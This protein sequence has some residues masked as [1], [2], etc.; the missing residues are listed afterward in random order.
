MPSVISNRF[1]Y[2]LLS[3]VAMMPAVMPVAVQASGAPAVVPTPAPPS[4]ADSDR[5]KLQAMDAYLQAQVRNDMFSGTALVTRDGEPVFVKSYGMANYELGAANTSDTTYPLGSV[6]K[7]FTAVAILQLQEQGKLKVG[8]PICRYLE[9][10][11]QSWQ[12]ITLHHLLTHTSGIPNF[13]GLPGW[14]EKLAMLS[15]TR[16]ELVALFRDLPLDF[17]PG[18]K[19][20][21]SNSGY[22]LLGVIIERVSGQRYDDYLEEKIFKPVGMTRT[23][24]GETRALVP[25]RATGYYSVGTDFISAR[26]VSPTSHLGTSGV[27]STV[28]DL[29]LWDK[30]LTA[31]RLISR[32]SRDAMFTPE[33][34]SYG[35]GWFVGER[36]GRPTQFHSGSDNGF[37]TNITRFPADGL[38]VIVLSNSDRTNA[39]GVSNDLAAIAFGA[40]YKL[41]KERL[42]DVLWNVMRDRG[43]TAALARHAELKRTAPTAYDF[44]DETLVTMGYDLFEVRRL[45][46]AEAVFE[47]NLQ[48]YPKSAYSY[49]GLADIAAAKGDK[50]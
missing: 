18:E 41:P 8:D 24:G 27:Y 12:G 37:S 42:G 22:A 47:Y 30:A 7:Q 16:S 2:I 15:Y 13:T 35:Y 21:Y 49:D 20:D 6:V 26:L 32:A 33:K 5:Q 25:G 9:T 36:H 17:A 3:L 44:G 39:G 10:C 14:D 45:A 48:Q 23:Y 31:D 4:K 29:L 1:P 46:E 19:F 28:S 34:N 40:P 11:P 43:V 38:T 50:A